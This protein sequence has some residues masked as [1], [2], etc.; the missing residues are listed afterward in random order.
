ME[1][2]HRPFLLIAIILLTI[3]LLSGCQ[4]AISSGVARYEK[5]TYTYKVVD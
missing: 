2:N 3:P 5:D 4:K 1:L